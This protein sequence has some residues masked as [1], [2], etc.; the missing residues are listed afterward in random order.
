MCVCVY[1][2]VDALKARAEASLKSPQGS[3]SNSRPQ[4]SRSG[5]GGGGGGGGGSTPRKPPSTGNSSSGSGSDAQQ[6]PYTAEQEAI[7]K[8]VQGVAKNGHYE[9]LGVNKSAGDNEIKKA[10]RKLALKLH[11]DKN[12]APSAEAAFKAISSAFDTLSDPQKKLEYD[13]YGTD[14]NSGPAGGGRG[15]FHGQQVNPE[16]IFEMFFNGGMPRQR[17]AR[18]GGGGFQS[19]HFGG[20]P[21][22]RQQ[23]QQQ[24]RGGGE[25]GGGNPFGQ[26]LQFLPILLFLFLSFGGMGGGVAPGS[27]SGYDRSHLPYSFVKDNRFRILKETTLLGEH[28]NIPYYVPDNFALRYARTLG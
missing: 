14:D 13:Q 24:Q 6:R 25:G 18:R 11:P 1:V 15:G 12:S 26:L 20:H 8:R 28:V 4:S 27:G 16:D 10:Y 7:A 9:A 5:G 21:Q 22:Q 17:G 19:F 3:S 2:G 23:Q